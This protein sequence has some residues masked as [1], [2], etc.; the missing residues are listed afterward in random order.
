MHSFKACQAFNSITNPFKMHSF[1]ITMNQITAVYR[2]YT[3][4]SRC[5]SELLCLVQVKNEKPSSVAKLPIKDEREQV[6]SPIA[7]SHQHP[8]HRLS[9]QSNLSLPA[10]M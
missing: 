1:Y 10:S 7:P 5:S 8:N 3:P 6:Q 2:Q 9:K 4:L